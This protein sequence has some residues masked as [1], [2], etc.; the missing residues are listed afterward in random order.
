MAQL[1]PFEWNGP[2]TGQYLCI[3]VFVCVVAVVVVDLICDVEKETEKTQI[4]SLNLVFFYKINW[5][6]GFQR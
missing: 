4:A 5:D 3:C 2:C 6:D 1:N